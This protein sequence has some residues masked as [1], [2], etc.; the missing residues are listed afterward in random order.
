[1]A[2]FT[3]TMPWSFAPEARASGVASPVGDQELIRRFLGTGDDD[4]FEILVQ[5]HRAGVLRLAASILGPGADSEAEDLTQ[6]VF[7]LVYR[8]LDTF[9][10]DCA[11]ATWIYRLTRNL[12]IDRLRRSVP[13][14]RRVDAEVLE[15]LPDRGARSDPQR[16][17][18]A[19]QRQDWMLRQVDRLGEPERSVVFL[20]YWLDRTIAEI[21]DLL[22]MKPGTVKSH[23]HRARQKLAR[24]L[25]ERERGD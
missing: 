11:F 21:G 6:D 2:V 7:V 17:A 1:M 12:A 5:R 13:G 18:A 3:S 25:R 8:K 19:G 20:H 16:V 15:G 9:R 22:E 14:G 10:G 23:L 4:Q 24:V